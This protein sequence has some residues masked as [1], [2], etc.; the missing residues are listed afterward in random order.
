MIKKSLI[1]LGILGGIF[2]WALLVHK[3]DDA[4]EVLQFA[5]WGSKSEVDILKPL[6][7]EFEKENPK[8]KNF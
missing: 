5:S 1:I 7:A 6:L 8:I 4:R 2:L 3:T